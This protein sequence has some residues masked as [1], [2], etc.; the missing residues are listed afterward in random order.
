[1]L[2]SEM[3][4]WNGC[5]FEV[6]GLRAERSGSLGFEWFNCKFNYSIRVYP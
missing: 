3:G 6:C 1:M 4:C 5:K 2:Q